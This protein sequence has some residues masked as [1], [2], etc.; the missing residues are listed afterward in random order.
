MI[1]NIKRDTASAIPKAARHDITTYTFPE[2]ST[3]TS[4]TNV[5]S[6]GGIPSYKIINRK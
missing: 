6:L 1:L 3:S 5:E 2:I 4:V